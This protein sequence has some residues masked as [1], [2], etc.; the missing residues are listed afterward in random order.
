M[1]NTVSGQIYMEGG[2]THNQD[3]HV[4][5]GCLRVIGTDHRLGKIP[6]EFD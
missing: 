6:S 5:T 1:V 3:C 2:M 4:Y